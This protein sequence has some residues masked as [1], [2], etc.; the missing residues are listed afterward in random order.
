LRE[1]EGAFRSE[2]LQYFIRRLQIAGR[3]PRLRIAPDADGQ[4]TAPGGMHLKN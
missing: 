2:S 4:L 1:E 3:C